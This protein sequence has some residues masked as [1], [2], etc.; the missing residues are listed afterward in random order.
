MRL[1]KQT[2]EK[3]KD[4]IAGVLPELLKKYGAKQFDGYLIGFP[5]DPEK[6]LIGLWVG[7]YGNDVSI[8]LIFTIHAQLP[9]VTEIE[10]YNYIDAINEYLEDFNP[11]IAGYTDGSYALIVKDGDRKSSIELLYSVTL[12]CP[13]DDCD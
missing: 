11:Q 6:T 8:K 9:G 5:T 4:D 1:V 12:V 7:E 2:M 13:K 10:A 3:I